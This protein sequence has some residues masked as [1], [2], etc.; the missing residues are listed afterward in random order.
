MTPNWQFQIDSYDAQGTKINRSWVCECAGQLLLYCL[1]KTMKFHCYHMGVQQFH[2][3]IFLVA[4]QIKE[5]VDLS[6]PKDL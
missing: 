2:T 4:P 3:V 5:Q 6:Y 1:F